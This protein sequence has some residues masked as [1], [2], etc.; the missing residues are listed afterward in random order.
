MEDDGQTFIYQRFI[1]PASGSV[2]FGKALDR[3]V[4]G[5]INEMVTLAKLWLAEGELSPHD[6]G[7]RLN[8]VLLSAHCPQEIG[9]VREAERGVQVAG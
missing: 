1:A 2:R 6:V 7:L 4:T 8:D 9:L 5:S 3:S